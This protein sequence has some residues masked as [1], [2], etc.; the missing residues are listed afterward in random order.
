MK[1]LLDESLPRSLKREL[2]GHEVSTVPEMGWSG[3]EN[4]ELLRL[5][6]GR[7][8]A[9]LTADQNL[10]FQQ[11]LAASGVPVIVLS[12]CTNRLEDLRPLVP[13]VLERL[14]GPLEPGKAIV[15]EA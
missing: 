5:M 13:S 7:F 12:A 14:Q 9:F 15:I 6:S 4:G 11:N 2:A 3:R 1:L 8:D 10:E